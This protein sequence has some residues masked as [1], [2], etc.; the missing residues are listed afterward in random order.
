MLPEY[1]YV[2]LLALSLSLTSVG[3][4]A[5]SSQQS[6]RVQCE[7]P[8]CTPT[9]CCSILM[10]RPMLAS[11]LSSIRSAGS[12][13]LRMLQQVRIPPNR[14]H[15]HMMP[16]PCNRRRLIALC[17]GASRG[18]TSCWAKT[19]QR[20]QQAN[21]DYTGGR[22]QR[23]SPV[24]TQ[25]NTPNT[26]HSRAPLLNI[27]CGIGWIVAMH[28]WLPAGSTVSATANCRGKLAL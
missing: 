22:A 5:R 2:Q 16:D 25:H 10:G 15:L 26:L 3:W 14:E 17:S 11:I 6:D 4:R 12:T 19:R 9:D 21:A 18:Q 27:A 24:A 1:Q 20:H 7:R 8:G 23:S 28:N 13:E